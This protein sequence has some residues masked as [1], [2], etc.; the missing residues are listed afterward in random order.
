VPGYRYAA[1][2]MLD[3]FLAVGISIDNVGRTVLFPTSVVL[4]TL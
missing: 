1:H 2:H 4:A 3:L